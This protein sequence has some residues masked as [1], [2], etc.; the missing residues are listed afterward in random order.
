EADDAAN[1]TAFRQHMDNFNACA[2]HV[3]HHGIHARREVAVSD[4][5]RGC[6]NEPSR[7]G[8]QTF[9]NAT[10]KFRHRSITTARGDRAESI[11]HSRD[12]PKQSQQRC[13]E[14]NGSKYRKEPFQLRYFQLRGFLY[15]VT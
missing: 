8:E 6:Y 15:N 1:W 4:K 10:G 3:M 14:S 9:V 11:D 13:Q 12:G 7:G 2:L 5:C